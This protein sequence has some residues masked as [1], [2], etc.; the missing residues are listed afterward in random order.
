MLARINF[1][2]CMGSNKRHG[3]WPAKSAIIELDH[4]G[5]T[6]RLKAKRVQLVKEFWIGV[7]GAGVFGLIFLAGV[8]GTSRIED[9]PNILPYF[10]A[11]AA[12]GFVACAAGTQIGAEGLR[13]WASQMFGID[14][15]TLAV[16]RIGIAISILVDLWM[17]ARDLE[18][19]YSDRGIFPLSMID[20]ATFPSFFH[21]SDLSIHVLNGSAWYQGML[22]VVAAGLALLLLVGYH[23]RVVTVGSWLLLVSMQTRNPLVMTGGDTLLRMLVFWGMFLPLGARYSID[24]AMNV[25]LTKRRS[26]IAD[27]ATFAMMVQVLCMYFMSGLLKS[28][29]MWHVDG[30]AVYYALSLDMLTTRTGQML[31]D[32]PTLLRGLTFFT[33]FLELAAPAIVFMPWRNAAWRFVFFLLFFGMHAGFWICMWIGVFP[34][35]GMV[36]VSVFVPSAVWDWIGGK[37]APAK[38]ARPAVY[39]DAASKSCRSIA[40]LMRELLML[41]SV[42]VRRFRPSDAGDAEPPH[43]LVVVDANGRRHARFDALVALARAAPLFRPVAWLLSLGPIPATGRW[44]CR[45]AAGGRAGRRAFFDRLSDVCFALRKRRIGVFWPIQPLVLA[46]LMFVVAYCVTS[47]DIWEHNWLRYPSTVHLFD[48]RV[49]VDPATIY[50]TCR[51]LRLDQNWGMFAPYPLLDDGWFVARGELA[52]GSEVDVWSGGPFTLDRPES[53]ANTYP[54]NRWRKYMELLRRRRESS[55]RD[56]RLQLRFCEY[57]CQRWNEHHPTEQRVERIELFFVSE[58]S[59]PPGVPVTHEPRRLVGYTCSAPSASETSPR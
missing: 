24:S 57:L 13:Q 32:F 34:F 56:F 35:V 49:E 39:C 43:R 53:I 25:S 7:L 15:R 1:F 38:Q 48:K 47:L 8:L 23:T 11:I 30:S 22:F 40:L 3:R 41:P 2:S 5:G 42:R 12:V 4:R 17:R 59:R 18:A 55:H 14:L 28:H 21:M 6:V 54:N 45:L 16:M 37:L 10:A 31:L 33:L 50:N 19:H 52:D 29:D 26:R 51:H 27:V 9:L 46:L 20:G 44:L 36:A 58:R